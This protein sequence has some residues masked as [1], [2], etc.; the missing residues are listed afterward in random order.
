MSAVKK[1]TAIEFIANCIELLT[2]TS[3]ENENG[4][5]KHENPFIT[6]YLLLWNGMEYRKR[7]D[8]VTC[9]LLICSDL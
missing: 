1:K 3:I 9:M 5:R 7:D 6:I 4:T 8:L 2:V